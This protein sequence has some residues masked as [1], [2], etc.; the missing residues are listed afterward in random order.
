MKHSSTPFALILVASAFFLSDVQHVSA[1]SLNPRSSESQVTQAQPSQNSAQTK[2]PSPSQV[3]TAVL[4]IRESSAEK[5]KAEQQTS[6]SGNTAKPPTHDTFWAEWVMAGAAVVY[7]FFAILQWRALKKTVDESKDLVVTANRQAKAAEAQVTNLEKTLVATEKA[8]AAAKQSADLAGES[9][10]IA[11]LALQNERPLLSAEMQEVNK[12]RTAEY[13]ASLKFRNRGRGSAIIQ[14]VRLE[15][16]LAMPNESREPTIDYPKAEKQMRIRE[17]ALG[18]GE[19]SSLYGFTGSQFDFN[20][21]ALDK[22]CG[23][24]QEKQLRFFGIVRYRDTVGNKYEMGYSFEYA[25]FQ[26]R[27]SFFYIQDSY[28]ITL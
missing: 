18:A 7:S 9:I 10:N 17:P 5:V 26:T 22:E 27:P 28:D 3:P 23:A 19:A 13:F 8:A 16:K 21:T 24:A 12:A 1:E 20:Y 4:S 6:G 11:K 14:E 2:E 25:S 15:L